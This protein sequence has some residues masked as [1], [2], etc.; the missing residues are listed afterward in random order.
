LNVAKRLTELM[1][2]N[3][4]FNS[5]LGHGSTFWFTLPTSDGDVASQR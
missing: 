1:G 3:I 2:G 5:D 4:G